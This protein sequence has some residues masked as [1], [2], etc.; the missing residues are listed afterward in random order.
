MQNM[1]NSSYNKNT[2]FNFG[3][4]A[5]FEKSDG[6][7]YGL[8]TDNY[9][10]LKNLI[11]QPSLMFSPHNDDKYLLLKNTTIPFEATKE[12]SW[13]INDKLLGKAQKINWQSKEAGEY[14]VKAVAD[15]GKKET[16]TIQINLEDK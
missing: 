8:K 9:D 14:K 1:Y 2:P 10:M 12:V 15:D 13:Y 16:V 6:I 11:L 5:E 4:V 3:D 7:E